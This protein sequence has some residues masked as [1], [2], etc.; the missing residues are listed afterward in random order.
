MRKQTQQYGLKL[1]RLYTILPTDRDEVRKLGEQLVRSG[2]RIT[3]FANHL[4]LPLTVSTSCAAMD[5]LVEEIKEAQHCIE[6]LRDDYGIQG[7]QIK[8]L[9]QE[10][11]DLGSKL[12]LARTKWA[13][14]RDAE[15]T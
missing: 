6:F 9:H 7:C 2:M 5:G 8:S 4:S 3:A 14:L 15:K 13:E 11:G 10:A 12:L 1:I